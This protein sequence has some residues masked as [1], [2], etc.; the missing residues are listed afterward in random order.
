[1]C[2]VLYRKKRGVIVNLILSRNTVSDHVCVLATG[3]MRCMSVMETAQLAISIRGVD[4]NLH[5]KHGTPA[6]SVKKKSG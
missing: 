6:I 5:A 2:D 4:S 3:L 1:M